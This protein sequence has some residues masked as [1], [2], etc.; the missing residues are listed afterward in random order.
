[1]HHQD[2]LRD[3][4]WAVIESLLPEVWEDKLRELGAYQRK[5]AFAGPSDL[6]RTLL[7]HVAEGHSFRVTATTA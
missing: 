1:M 3:E 6:S 5:P 2:I 4:D 7:I